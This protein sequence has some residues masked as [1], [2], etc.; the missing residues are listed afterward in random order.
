MATH[1]VKSWPEFFKA[2]VAGQP[3][4]LRD[5]DRRFKSGDF[6]RF[7]EFDDRVGKYTGAELIK[8]ITHVMENTIG[9]GSITPMVGLHRGYAILGLA[10]V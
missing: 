8:R 1:D 9:G 2:L 4:D 3:F 5:N 7:R 6:I 10:D